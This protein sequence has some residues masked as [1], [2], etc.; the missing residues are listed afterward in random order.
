MLRKRFVFTKFHPVHWATISSI[1]ERLGG[2]DGHA[3]IL[4]MQKSDEPINGLCS[5]IS[6]EV[7]DLGGGLR[8][9]SGPPGERAESS[10]LAIGSG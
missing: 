8:A 10:C 6:S 2:T 3:F 5:V 9:A 7:S 4:R 1:Q